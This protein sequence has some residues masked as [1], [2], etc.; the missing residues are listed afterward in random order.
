MADI[1]DDL[2]GMTHEKVHNNANKYLLHIWM[3]AEVD[4]NQRLII[5]LGL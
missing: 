4:F 3:S 5:G 2:R 1:I